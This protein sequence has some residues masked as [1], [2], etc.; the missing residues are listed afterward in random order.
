METFRQNVISTVEDKLLNAHRDLELEI[1][2]TVDKFNKKV[3]E[4]LSDVRSQQYV[5]ESDNSMSK[6]KFY[7]TEKSF[8]IKSSLLSDLFKISDYRTLY[9][10]VVASF[11]ALAFNLVVVD[12]VDKGSLFDFETLHW[13][14]SG[15]LNLIFPW[16]CLC[17]VAYSVIPF[18][19]VRH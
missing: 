10:I 7:F 8:H 11:V 14:F 16:L 3:G 4:T 15:A 6:K 19:S 12:Y 5:A 2:K 1:Q 9:N 17:A 18:V 13:C